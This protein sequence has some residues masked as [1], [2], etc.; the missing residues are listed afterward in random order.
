MFR[1]YLK[2]AFRTL[3]K[4]RLFTGINLLGLSLGLASAGVLILFIQRGMTWDTFH[5]DN[6][7]IYFVQTEGKDGRYNQTVHPI[8]GQLVKTYPEIKTGTHFQG[9]NNVWINYKGKDIQGNTKYVDSSFFDVFSFKLRYG[10]AAT[11]LKKRESILINQ[12][13]SL[14]LFGDKNPV[15]ETVAVNDTLNFT[16]TGV[17][18]QVPANSSVQFEVLIPIANL[19]ADKNFASG[20]DWY[21]TFSTVYLKLTKGANVAKLEKQFPQFGKAHFG[22]E[23]KNRKLHVVPLTEYIH[24]ENPA[25]KWMIYGATAIAVF[26][27]LII[28]INLLNLNTA[29]AFTRAKEVAVRKVT[30]S[31]LKQILIQFWTESGIVLVASFICAIIIAI[32]YLVPQFNEFRQG[33]MQLVLS[34]K[35]DYVTVL[36]LAGIIGLIAVVAGTYPA[37]HLNRLDL[38]DTIKG[39]LSGKTQ[40]GKW[41]KG[42]LIV[43]QF[44]IA[45]GLVI[46]AIT[47]RKQISFMRTADMGF[48]KDDVVVVPSDLQYKNEEAA[49][50]QFKPILDDLNRDSRVKSVATSGVVPTKYWSNYNMYLPEGETNKE[51]R[52][53]H[54]GAGARYAE[55]YG[56]K[57]VEGRDFSDDIDKKGENHPVVINE[58]AM[59]AMGWTTA[60]GKR[61]RQKNNP[62]TYT[63]I[64]VMKDFHYQE[65]K[66]KIEPLLHWY[67]PTGL[68]AYLSI[69]LNDIH[70]AKSV[71]AGLEAKMKKIPA[72]KPFNS[73]YVSDELSRQYNHLD[74]IWKMVNFVTIL[75]IIIAL[76]GIFGLITLAANQRTK[77]VG[78]RKVL[79]ASVGEIA[80][81]LAKDFVILVLVSIVI[82]LPVAYSF[83]VSYLQSYDYHTNIDWYIYAL[84]GI[85]ALVLTLCT[86]GFQSVK[87]ALMDPVRSLKSE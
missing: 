35:Q 15:G 53:K 4:N 34:W 6:D 59:N 13:I 7:Q 48:E 28:S 75:A 40:S 76:A 78:I 39:K 41:T 32:L 3:W 12:D 63:V 69:K 27:L 45:F 73:F 80:F 55:T 9:W 86:V 37:L 56:I 31:T 2:I 42:T 81:L 62:E 49:M 10:N 57:M 43:I 71:L 87:A 64:G 14:A 79:G 24:Q 16:V 65:L 47:V 17:I 22:S 38:R 46:G 1:N 52:F 58:S 44:V 67:E 26:I 18:D 11:A 70:Q 51:V 54:V 83:E 30:G 77:E 20:A 74:G 50:S 23:A 8:L 82:G 25:F 33:R 5:K 60:V 36:T 61:L 66:D 29:I 84:A 21:N 68:N 19:E 85:A 72:R